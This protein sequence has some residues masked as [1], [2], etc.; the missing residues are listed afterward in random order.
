MAVNPN[1]SASTNA[2]GEFGEGLVRTSFSR[3]VRSIYRR[4]LFRVAGLGDKFPI[5]DFLVEVLDGNEDS[6]GFFFVQAKST[7]TSKPTSKRLK[8]KID[9]VKFNKL[10]A[11][12]APTFLVGVDIMAEKVFLIAAPKP[13]KKKIYSIT[14]SFDLIDDSVRINLYNEVVGYW[15]KTKAKLNKRKTQFSNEL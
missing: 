5:A 14:K 9:L 13:K 11:T 8:L 10:A 12:P 4:P 1:I 7:S 3:P 6:L 2:I 15:R